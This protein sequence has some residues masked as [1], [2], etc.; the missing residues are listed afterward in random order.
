VGFLRKLKE[1]AEK[2]IEKG[3]ELGTK[4]FDAAK[5]A[6]G[7]GY[8][9]ARGESGPNERGVPTTDPSPDNHSIEPQTETK[10]TTASPSAADHEAL[11]ILKTRLAKGE[12]SPQQ[13]EEMRN[14]LVGSD[15]NHLSASD[16]SSPIDLKDTTATYSKWLDSFR[17]LKENNKKEASRETERMV[18]SNPSDS[19]AW[20]ARAMALNYASE[21]AK[22][23]ESIEKA[24]SIDPNFA[25]GW[26]VKGICLE[27]LD[28]P[29]EANLA[30][31]KA[32]SINPKDA[33]LWTIKAENLI[34][35]GRH[36]E[37][38]EAATRAIG[39]NP[40]DELAWFIQGTALLSLEK[41]SEA[42]QRFERAILEAD[43]TLAK[44]NNDLFA[45]NVKANS[46]GRLGKLKEAGE[47]KK[48]REKVLE[49]AGQKVRW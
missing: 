16:G 42:S 3:T 2:G 13:F 39:N 33:I 31:D 21:H 10:V 4:G 38:F 9:K 37:A 47:L 32:I 45:L 34:D 40:Q 8:E 5:D 29:D 7:K 27:R 48:K 6:A 36:E 15:E 28:R 49:H 12:I 17:P 30:Y 35:L 41:K 25:R 46:L 1:T 14:V 43:K 22:A 20:F 26:Y 19:I 18:Q 24:I 44:D 23:L 11:A